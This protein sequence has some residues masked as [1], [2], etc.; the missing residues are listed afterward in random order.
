M[1]E[2]KCLTST[3]KNKRWS[4]F[5]QRHK[6]NA[7]FLNGSINLHPSLDSVRWRLMCNTMQQQANFESA[8]KHVNCQGMQG[9]SKLCS[10]STCEHAHVT[11]T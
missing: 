6:A 8:E 11:Y 1:C 4:L 3:W 10:K 2:T 7:A 9:E 5:S